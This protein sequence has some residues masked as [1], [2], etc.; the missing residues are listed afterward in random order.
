MLFRS[1]DL[2]IGRFFWNLGGDK[3]LK[4][5]VIFLKAQVNTDYLFSLEIHDFDIQKK[6]PTS[7]LANQLVLIQTKDAYN[8]KHTILLEDAVP[9]NENVFV[10]VKYLGSQLPGNRIELFTSNRWKSKSTYERYLN[11]D[12]SEGTDAFFLKN[13]IRKGNNNILMQIQVLGK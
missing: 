3:F 4:S 5:V 13:S 12:W 10:S 11:R 2:E 8:Y 1:P 9:I 7:L 6:K